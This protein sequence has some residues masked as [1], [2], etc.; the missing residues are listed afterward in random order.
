[1]ALPPDIDPELVFESTHCGGLHYLEGNPH[2]FTGRMA[3]WC[4]KYQ[5]DITLSLSEMTHLSPPARYWVTGYLA[6]SERP[7]PEFA[8]ESAEAAWNEARRQYRATG[9]WPEDV[10]DC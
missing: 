6:G 9:E 2:T 7:P 10:Y 5:A 8:D 3:V 4:E 1:M